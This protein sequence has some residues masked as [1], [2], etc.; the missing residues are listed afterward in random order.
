MN[1]KVLIRIN[2]LLFFITMI[3]HIQTYDKNV[4]LI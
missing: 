1:I 3:A 4:T 2:L